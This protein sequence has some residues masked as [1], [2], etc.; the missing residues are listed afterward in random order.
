MPQT[1]VVL[2]LWAQ[3]LQERVLS[4]GAE[5]TLPYPEEVTVPKLVALTL[6]SPRMSV[7][8]GGGGA[9]KF[10]GSRSTPVGFGV[11]LIP[12]TFPA[13]R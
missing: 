12:N 3:G 4:R 6:E 2:Q 9:Q 5:S 11:R 8:A 10:A 7:T 13:P 1:L